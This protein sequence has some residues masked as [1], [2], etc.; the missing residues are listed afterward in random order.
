MT[1]YPIIIIGAGGHA[2]VVI[3]TIKKIG[4]SVISGITDLDPA[5]KGMEILGVRVIGNDEII[6]GYVPGSIRLVNGLGSTDVSDRR[7][8]IFE[9]FKKKG[10]IF[11]KLVHPSAIVARD[12]VLGEG[13]QIMA[14]AIIQPGCRIGNNVIVNT[15]ASMDHDCLVKDHVH[16][17]PRAV[18]SGQVTIG[19]MSHI[20]TSAV[21]IQ[22]LS[23]GEATLVGAGAL[24]V[25]D[26]PSGVRALGIPAKVRAG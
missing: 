26:I 5:K 25:N 3:D 18:L 14:G 6:Q 11:K 2:K 20:G 9:R 12:V 23:V 21:I 8:R 22:G 17:A 13:V 19:A 4:A 16:L 7:M 15:G 10:Y 1:D 24:V